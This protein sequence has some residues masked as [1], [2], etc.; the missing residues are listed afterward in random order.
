MNLAHAHP[1]GPAGLELESLH[2]THHH[3][4][5]S[6]HEHAAAGKAAHKNARRGRKTAAKGKKSRG[7]KKVEEDLIIESPWAGAY[8]YPAYG[9]YGAYGGYGA[10]PY[11]G[12]ADYA[13]YGVAA[14]YANIAAPAYGFASP[15]ATAAA[16]VGTTL[17]LDGVTVAEYPNYGVGWAG[18]WDTLNAPVVAP[19]AGMID[20]VVAAPV[21]VAEGWGAWG[22]PIAEPYLD[23]PNYTWLP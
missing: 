20:P 7:G 19:T 23:V 9:A 11:A 17:A 6:H 13:A 3:H 18:A 12:V 14:P 1:E 5:K 4:H 22:A 21:A 10:Y 15:V 16:P 2:R 8:G